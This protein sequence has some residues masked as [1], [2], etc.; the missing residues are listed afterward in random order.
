MKISLNK[1]EFWIAIFGLIIALIGAIPQIITWCK[2]TEIVGK[3]ISQYG[4]FVTFPQKETP[5][6]VYVQ[7]LSVFSRNN[8]FYLNNIK[9][10]I[11]YPSNEKEIEGKIW[12]WKTKSLSLT[13]NENGQE[14]KKTLSIS[15]NEYINHFSVLPKNSSIVGY[16]SFSIDYQQ[17]EAFEYI[18]YT[19][20]DFNNNSKELI[21]V[22]SNLLPNKLSHD[23]SIWE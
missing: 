14:I 17:D 9:V 16:L 7:K 19:F 21:V 15:S 5:E 13:F 6:I 2:K 10:R 3:V 18:V 4:S 1:W 20:I 11:K 12:N 23:D 22:G 8:E